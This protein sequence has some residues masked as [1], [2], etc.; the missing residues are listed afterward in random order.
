MSSRAPVPKQSRTQS[1]MYPSV[2][3]ASDTPCR[4]SSLSAYSIS[5]T[6]STGIMGLG[7]SHV[8]GLSRAPSPPAIITAFIFYSSDRFICR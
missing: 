7:I 4:L 6:S 3:A 5:G 1:G 8:S 2:T